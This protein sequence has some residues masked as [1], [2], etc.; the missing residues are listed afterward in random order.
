MTETATKTSAKQKAADPYR[1]KRVIVWNPENDFRL[2]DQAPLRGYE[3]VRQ[4]V[5][6]WVDSTA[7]GKVK[8]TTQPQFR[9]L[10]LKPGLNWVEASEWETAMAV[11]AERHSAEAAEGNPKAVDE[12][13]ELLGCRAI[14]AFEPGETV[15][16][17]RQ[18]TG[19][20]EDYSAQE[21]RRLM[22]Q[23]DD[24]GALQEYAKRTQD[25]T[26]GQIIQ[27]R[28]DSLNTGY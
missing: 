12:I 1:G 23:V 16:S 5:F 21:I 11:S 9:E 17:T 4:Y 14:L 2:G 26:L 19:N 20:L 18:F 28:I 22:A 24:V 6:C 27:E 7:S 13:S 25:Y 15:K 8:Q 10:L 3:M